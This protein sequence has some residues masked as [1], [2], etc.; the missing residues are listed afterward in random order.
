MRRLI[1]FLFIALNIISI[2]SCDDQVD[3]KSDFKDVYA[4]N[5]IIRG[6]TSLQIA[7]IS[8]SYN[9]D[10]YDPLLNTNDP[11]IKGAT[12]K[13]TYGDNRITYTFRDSSVFRSTYSRYST[14]MNIYYIHDFKPETNSKISIEA[15]LPNGQTLKSNSTTYFLSADFI[16]VNSH[17]FPL[18]S[19]VY[20]NF[21]VFKWNRL[22]MRNKIVNV[23]FGPEL[24]L[25]YFKIENGARVA[26]EKKVPSYYYNGLSVP[27]LLK[28]IKEFSFDTLSVRKTIEEISTGDSNKENYIIDKMVFRLFAVDKDLATYYS[29]NRTFNEEFSVRVVQPNYSN[30]DGGFGLFGT[31]SSA[32]LDISIKPS[33]ITS[34]GYKY[35]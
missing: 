25:K 16:D 28:D 20:G 21:F 30:I 3:P 6:D 22:D 24:I 27:P 17:L 18:P 10:G 1:F 7:T 4:L 33:Y 35:Y 29:S 23:Y 12:I 9:L 2:I 5:C 26:Y 32:Q 34:F 31:I 19:T 13:L 8:R 14:P 11:F 15:V